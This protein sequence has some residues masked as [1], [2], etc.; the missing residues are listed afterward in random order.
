[1]RDENDLVSVLAV[2]ELPIERKLRENVDGLG[3]RV[4]GLLLAILHLPDER[5][6]ARIGELY[7]DVRTRA[8]AEL[9]IDAEVDPLFKE[10]VILELRRAVNPS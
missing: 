2:E 6:A 10:L 8:F 4:R 3:P 5:R 9:L 1:M 7:A